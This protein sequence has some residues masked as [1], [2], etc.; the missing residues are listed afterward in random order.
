MS[1]LSWCLPLCISL[2][3][4]WIISTVSR[5]NGNAHSL[6]NIPG[7]R[8]DSFWLGNISQFLSKDGGSF[9][10]KLLQRYGLVVRLHSLFSRPM[11]YISDPKALHSILMKEVEAYKEPDGFMAINM[12]VFGPGLVSTTGMQHRRQRKMLNPVFS[13]N[14]MRYLLPTFYSVAHKLRGAISQR[15]R[16]GPQDFDILHWMSRSAL[17]VVG[18]GGL[19]HSFDSFE[20]DEQDPYGEAMKAL[21][22]ALRGLIMIS[23]ILPFL[24]RIG[25][26]WLQ[27]RILDAIP[28]HDIRTVKHSVGVMFDKANEVYSARVAALNAGDETVMHQVGE[29]KDI[30]STLIRTNQ[31]AS[32]Q[33]KLPEDEVISQIS[34][35]VFGATDTSSNTLSHILELLAIHPD[36]QSKLRDELLTARAAEGIPYDQLNQLPYL[37]AVVRETLR[38]QVIDYDCWYPPITLLYRVP[39]RDVI[40]PLYKPAHGV[41]GTMITELH[42]NKGTEIALGIGSIN[43][44]EELWG[45]DALVWDPQ[46]WLSPLPKAISEAR[47]PGVYANMLTFL[48]GPKACIGY[49]F[50]EVGIKVTLAVLLSHFTFALTEEKIVWNLAVISYPTVEPDR[51]NPRL[52]LR[53]GELTEGTA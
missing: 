2:L 53:V 8:S 15:V 7:P 22:P 26:A 34:T 41:D 17:E 43:T 44:S 3:S 45:E 29:G 14:H 11:L 40:L 10:S 47:I 51:V 16:D 1:A 33:E 27:R 6:W 5:Q 30:M 25:P 13:V 48:E 36:I 50:A 38:R 35:L 52:P 28:H 39:E 46:R 21:T 20:S 32:G 19:G 4:I 31:N 42:L 18:Q 37:D 23:P 49:K 24:S 12:L 9:H